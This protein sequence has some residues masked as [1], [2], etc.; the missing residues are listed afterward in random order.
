MATNRFSETACKIRRREFLKIVSLTAG[1]LALGGLSDVFALTAKRISIATGGIGSVYFTVGGKIAG[2]LTE[3]SGIEAVAEITSGSPDNCGLVGSKKSDFGLVSADIAYNAFRG[4]GPF[5]G[6]PL[7]IRILTALYPNYT[8][9]VTLGNKGISKITDLA[10]KT[11]AAGIEGSGTQITALR[12]LEAAGF[13][14]NGGSNIKVVNIAA[15]ES[16]RALRDGKI[17]AYIWS[18]GIPAASL[19]D[20]A[21]TPG[22]TIALISHGNLVPVINT[23]HGPVYFKSTIPGSTYPGIT[24]DTTVCAVSNAIICHK[25]MDTRSAYNTIRIIFQHLK[26]LAAVHTQTRHISLEAGASITSMWYHPGA[27][28]YFSEHGLKVPAM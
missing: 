2:L 8:H 13:N 12:L 6:N 22:L 14:T 15:S 26:E 28:Q 20:L 9:I 1:S 10:G 17:D 19:R 3:Y 18:G 5:E 7:P 16:P 27:Q 24:D 4:T 25:D 11:V 21:K 23:K